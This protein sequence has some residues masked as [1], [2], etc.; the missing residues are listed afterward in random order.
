MPGKIP[1]LRLSAEY[2]YAS[3]DRDPHDGRRQTFD[4]LYATAHDKYGL[5]DQVGWRNLHDV[6]VGWEAKPVPALTVW[7][8]YHNW[9]LASARDALYAG[10]SSVLAVRPDGSAGAHVGQEID[11]QAM[12]TFSKHLQLGAGVGHIF[13]GEFLKRTSPGKSYTYPYLMLNCSF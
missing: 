10:N 5:T 13:P 7:S 3:G 4:Q 1:G 2:N 8:N 12:N 6:R 9:W 11:L